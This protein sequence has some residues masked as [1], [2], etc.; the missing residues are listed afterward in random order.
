MSIYPIS[1]LGKT[2]FETQFY[3][4][5]LPYQFESQFSFL[6]LGNDRVMIGQLPYLL[7]PIIA[8]SLPFHY[9]TDWLTFLPLVFKRSQVKSAQSSRDVVALRSA[10][11]RASRT[12]FEH[13][14][15]VRGDHGEGADSLR[16]RWWCWAINHLVDD[17]LYLIVVINQF[18]WF[19]I[20]T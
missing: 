9:P 3:P 7:Y 12:S 1:L 13:V 14:A 6:P 19:T 17:Y 11:M 8:L 20:C 4:I 16:T 2:L 18:Y 5:S 15:A 10:V